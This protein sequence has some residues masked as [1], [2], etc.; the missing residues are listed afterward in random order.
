MVLNYKTVSFTELSTQDLYQLLQLRSAV[1]VLEQNCAYLDIDDLDQQATH[2]LGFASESTLVAYARI[3]KPQLCNNTHCSIGRVV[4]KKNMR[5]HRL[6]H[7]IM[8]YAIK[9]ALSLYPN[10]PI[11][12]SAQTYL[13]SFYE[14]LGFVNTGHFY[15]E[16]EIPHQEMVYKP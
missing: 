12:I 3:L 2:L 8:Q 14:S 5:Q 6:G 10:M 15:L 1:F 11:Q 4:V 16:D 13:T 7:Q 9:Q